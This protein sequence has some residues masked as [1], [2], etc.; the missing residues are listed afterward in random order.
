MH[1]ISCSIILLLSILSA[2]VQTETNVPKNQ[3]A[4]KING[5]KI[6]SWWIEQAIRFNYTR[7]NIKLLKEFNSIVK[8]DTLTN[9]NAEHVDPGYGR[10]FNVMSVNLDDEPGNELIC[11]FGW[12]Y[13]SPDLCVFKQIKGDWYLIYREAIDTFYGSP[14]LYVANC[15]SKNKTFYLR[16]VYDHGSGIYIDGYSFYKLINN[17]VYKCLDLINDAHIY[18]WGLYMNQAVKTSF[19]FHGDENDYLSV[20][21]VYNFFPGSIY[22]ADCPWCAHED[23]SLINGDKNVGYKWNNRKFIYELDIQPYEN[24]PYDLTAKKI[25]CFGNFG[26][27]TLF[28]NAF[29]LQIDQTIKTGTSR[30]KKILKKYLALVK[31]DQKAITMELEKKTAAGGTSFYGPKK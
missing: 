24:Q 9:S 17:K 23:I 28:V 14:T 3:R 1:R 25:A 4:D 31:R 26:N 20:D 19:E 30:Q 22:K 13:S 21:Y 10:V 6:P 8:P 7:N 16:R 12:D 27:D 11:L 29:R 2:C 15:F 18:G 5:I